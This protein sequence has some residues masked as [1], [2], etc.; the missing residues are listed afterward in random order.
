MEWFDAKTNPPT[1]EGRY[2]CITKGCIVRSY[3]V[4]SYSTYL[5]SV[6][7]YDFQ[8]EQRPGWYEYDSEWGYYEFP[9][10]E[11]WMPLPEPPAV[12]KFEKIYL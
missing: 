5:E 10:V 6:N 4:L 11:Y 3:E 12:I 8:G 7:E 2:L 9:D 1:E